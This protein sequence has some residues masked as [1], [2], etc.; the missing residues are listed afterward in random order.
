MSGDGLTECQAEAI[1]VQILQY[2]DVFSMQDDEYGKVDVVKHHIDTDDHHP[3]NQALRRIPYA[4]R[5]AMLKL[6]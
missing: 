1:C 2:H 4:Q 3:I 6:V 5:A